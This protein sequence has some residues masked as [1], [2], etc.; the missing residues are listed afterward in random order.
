MTAV[1]DWRGRPI[2]PGAL[3][4]YA[5][6]YAGKCMVEGYVLAENHLTLTGL[7]RV[8]IV[9]VS[10]GGNHWQIGTTVRVS[11]EHLTVLATPAERGLS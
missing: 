2:E 5:S 9:A 10:R 3:V 7:V 11:P 1:V 8:E 6:E 4:V